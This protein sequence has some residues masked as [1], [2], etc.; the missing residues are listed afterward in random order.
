MNQLLAQVAHAYARLAPRERT[1][2]Q[3]AI[4]LSIGVVLWLLVAGVGDAKAELRTRIGS[5]E[6]QLE[7]I[8][9]LRAEYLRLERLAASATDTTVPDSFSLFSFL[10]GAGKNAVTREKVLAL[11]PS[12]RAVGDR[13][14]EQ[15]VEMKLAG[16]SLQQLVDLLHQIENARAPLSILRLQMKKQASDPYAFDITLVVS[17]LG[18]G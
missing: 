13:L 11:S 8:H 7:E 6:R 9:R 10:D 17:S 4:A 15:S 3:V 1:L 12:S 2:L 14:V 18:P 5:K 16:V